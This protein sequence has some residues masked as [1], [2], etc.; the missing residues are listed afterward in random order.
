MVFSSI[1]FIFIFIPILILVYYISP[2]KLRNFIMFISSLIFYA[3]GEPIYILL[4][5]YSIIFNY[6]MGIDIGKK[7]EKEKNPKFTLIFTLIINILI[8]GFFKYYDFLIEN[9]NNII[10]I[11]LPSHNLSLPIGLSFYTFQAISYIIDVYKCKSKYQKNIISFGLY[12]SMFPQLVAGPIVQYS[13]IDYQLKNRKESFEL[14]GK[15]TFYF[16]WGLFKKVLLAN[17]MGII[18]ESI[19][20]FSNISTF[21]AWIGALSYT[22]QIYFDFSGYSDMAIGL[23]Y[24]FGFKIKE[25]FNYPYLS[26]N[27]TEFW[28]KWHISLG[29][30]FREYIYIPLGGNKVS[31]IKHIRNIFIVWFLTGFWH[32]A[33]WNFI[34]WGIY[35]AIILI[36]EKY[37]LK[38]LLNI[39]PSFLSHIYTMFIVIIGWVF[40]FNEDINKALDYL[41]IMLSIGNISLFDNISLYYIYSSGISFIICFIFSTPLIHKILSNTIINKKYDTGL[42]ICL[43]HIILFIITISYIISDTYNPFLYFR[44]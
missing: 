20:N 11:N 14:F 2:K 38:K 39:L 28:R 25:N 37:L 32:G 22:F 1:L 7:L 5:I 18:F 6:F 26:K 21:T 4:M 40:F 13:D 43:T 36:I 8:L 24:M 19:L 35:Y 29:N 9:I 3:W 27:I 17:R 41:K 34:V 33:N 30:W 23:G 31:T 15:G 44:F 42:Y 12:I 16:M 10:N